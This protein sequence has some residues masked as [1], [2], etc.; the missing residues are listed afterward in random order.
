MYLDVVSGPNLGGHAF[1]IIIFESLFGHIFYVI[2]F[3]Y[4]LDMVLETYFGCVGHV[5]TNLYEEMH[6]ILT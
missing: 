3:G 1:G 2:Y 6:F 5:Y 4:P